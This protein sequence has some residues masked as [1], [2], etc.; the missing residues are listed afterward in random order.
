[1]TSLSDVFKAYDIRGVVP[2]ELERRPVP[3]HRR[4]RRPASPV[5]RRLLVARDMRESGVELVRR[6]RRRGPLRGGDGGRPRPGLDRPAL[7][8]GR[9]PRRARGHVHRVAQPGPVQRAQ[10]LPVRGPP[11]RAGHR[12]GRDPGHGRGAARR[13]GD[14]GPPELDPA[15]SAPLEERSVLDA[16][17]DHV[18]SFVDARRAATAARWWPTP[19]T[20]WAGLVVP[21]V[22]E[23]LP[24]E[25][26]DPLPRARR[27]L[28][29]PS[30]RPHPAGEPGRP[31]RRPCSSAGPTSAWPSTATPT[32]SSWSTS[33]PSRCRAR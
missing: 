31:A 8:R 22:F 16:Y 32:G 11:D 15:G 26:R 1:M 21:E 2:D 6:L 29:E 18:R 30:G 13:V 17:A 28:P 33:R 4:G 9:E 14:D 25:R 27:E 24:F 23:G 7:L 19:P 3:G 12:A 10:A 5:S 20:A